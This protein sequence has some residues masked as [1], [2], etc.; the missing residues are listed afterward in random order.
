MRD[1]VGG[2]CQEH[3]AHQPEENRVCASI[4]RIDYAH[5]LRTSTRRA[6]IVHML[7]APPPCSPRGPM[8]TLAAPHSFSPCRRLRTNHAPPPE[9]SATS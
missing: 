9:R 5:W 8:R 7:A 1:P 3:T 6:S 2:C 4:M